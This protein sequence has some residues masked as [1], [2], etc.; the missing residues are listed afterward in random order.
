MTAEARPGLSVILVNYNDEA[1]LGT[2]LTSLAAHPPSG[3]HEVI[4]VDNASTDGSALAGAARFPDVRFI[5]NRENRGFG[6]AN[7]QAVRESGGGLLLFLNTDTE[8]TAGA[9][10]LL[11]DALVASPAA[12]AAGPALLRGTGEFQVSFGNRVDFFG[13]TIQKL[14]LNPLYGRRLKRMRLAR[15]VGWLSA[16]CLLVRREAF[17]AAGGFDE[18]FFIYFEDID[19]CRRMRKAGGKLL[20][21]PA[22]RIVHEGGAATA[23][24]KAGSRL[25][26]RKSQ[27][28]YYR[29]H[30][31]KVSWRLLRAA[32]R[33]NI[34]LA[35]LAGRFRGEDGR[36]LLAEYRKLLGEKT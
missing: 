26:Y 36:V 18:G 33:L 32:M 20:F 12:A 22:A 23:S 35:R 6:A 8:V 21:V 31:P 28:R 11:R 16:A 10:D 2:C 29:K 25:E 7:N 15:E 30:G 9:L 24:R 4:V 13:Q 3:P 17:E 19:L 5:F 27:L 34:A 14:A 1:H